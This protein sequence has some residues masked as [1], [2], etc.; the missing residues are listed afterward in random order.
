[1]QL[2]KY[3]RLK[4]IYNGQVIKIN[5]IFSEMVLSKIPLYVSEDVKDISIIRFDSN[6]IV[7]ITNKEF[8]K[9]NKEVF[10]IY[11]IYSILSEKWGN[12]SK[13]DIVLAYWFGFTKVI[14]LIQ[15]GNLGK[16]DN[17]RIAIL[18]NEIKYGQNRN[19]PSINDILNKVQFIEVV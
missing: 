14:S 3:E 17:D 12:S 19:V 1:M 10:N 18:E 7:A 2:R 9:S 15:S 13:I 5:C 4:M 8:K 6:D 11:I 16:T